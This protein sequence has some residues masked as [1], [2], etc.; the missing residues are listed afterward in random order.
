MA[1]IELKKGVPT[2]A[3]KSYKD[4][5]EEYKSKIAKYDQEK[6]EI[7]KKA[8]SLEVARDEALAHSKALGFAVI[9]LQL[10]VMIMSITTLLKR[11][12]LWML[13][14]AVGAVGVLWF[15]NGLMLLF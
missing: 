10:A 11:K 3:V 2:S 8:K 6:D 7:S 14:V 12:R 13:G 1:V 5:I 15:V 9:L 4:R